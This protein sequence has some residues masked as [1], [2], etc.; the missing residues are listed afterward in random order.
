MI[1]HMNNEAVHSH[2]EAVLNA[3]RRDHSYTDE[4]VRRICTN[5]VRR[6]GRLK[7]AKEKDLSELKADELPEDFAG[8]ETY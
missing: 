5:I 1:G 7:A 6:I 3:L 4:Q 2:A 8:R